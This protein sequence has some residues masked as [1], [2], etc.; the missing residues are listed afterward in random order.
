MLISAVT[1]SDIKLYAKIES[2]SLED[3]LLTAILVAGK[4]YIKSHTGLTTEQL[5]E[6]EDLT[7][8]L[9]ILC[10]DMYEQRQYIVQHDKVNVVI[11]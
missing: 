3:N 8:A 10:S 6:H 1:I 11:K 9:L 2:G 4:E 7:I 5:D